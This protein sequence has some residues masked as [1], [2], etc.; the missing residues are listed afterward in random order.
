MDLKEL[1]EFRDI[2]SKSVSA[3]DDVIALVEL[4]DTAEGERPPTDSEKE[5]METALRNVAVE[6]E[7]L[8]LIKARAV[9]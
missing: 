1:K 3:L 9:K 8:R 6:M 5:R 2:F 7:K 4:A